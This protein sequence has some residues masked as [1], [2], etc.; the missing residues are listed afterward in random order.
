MEKLKNIK[1]DH[2]SDV[3]FEDD[4]AYQLF[5]VYLRCEI[6]EIINFELRL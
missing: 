6:Y 1:M 3:N 2:A 5:K 4:S